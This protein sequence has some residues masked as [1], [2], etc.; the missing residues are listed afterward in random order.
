MA[1]LDKEDGQL[2]AESFMQALSSIQKQ[3]SEDMQQNRFE[4]T[5]TQGIQAKFIYHIPPDRTEFTSEPNPD[6]VS[7]YIHRF[8]L[9]NPVPTPAGVSSI[10]LNDDG[11]VTF[12]FR[13]SVP[14]PLTFFV[15]FVK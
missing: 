1:T 11:S 4:P 12:K 3:K 15:F 14:Y 9:G 5:L 7:A 2:I 8:V 13:K 6:L 10:E